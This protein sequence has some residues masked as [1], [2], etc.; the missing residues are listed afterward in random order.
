MKT[1]N[2]EIN[3]PLIPRLQTV[4]NAAVNS[5]ATA[6][7]THGSYNTQT[8]VTTHKQQL[9]RTNSS[10][11]AQTAVTSHKQQLQHTNSSYTQEVYLKKFHTIKIHSQSQHKLL[12]CDSKYVLNYFILKVKVKQPYYRP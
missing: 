2:T 11:N 6:K 12:H 10:Y 1:I 8:A 4:T 3:F 9:Q 7:H 5:S